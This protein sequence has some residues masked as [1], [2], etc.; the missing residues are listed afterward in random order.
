M[1]QQKDSVA[2]ISQ[3]SE[4]EANDDTFEDAKSEQHSSIQDM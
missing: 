1:L 4:S 2:A 3:P